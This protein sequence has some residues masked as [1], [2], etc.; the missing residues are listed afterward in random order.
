MLGN[1]VA[2][3]PL[4]LKMERR[5]RHRVSMA[6]PRAIAAA[7]Q[8]DQSA[9]MTTLL[10]TATSNPAKATAVPYRATLIRRQRAP[11]QS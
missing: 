5:T 10:A 1:I 4:F 3:W 2:T 7:S 6:H 11:F 9:L 8:Y